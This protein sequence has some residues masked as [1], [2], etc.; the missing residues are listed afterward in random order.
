MLNISDLQVGTFLIYNGAPH[1]LIYREHSKLGRG[2]AILRSKI[3]NLLT[4]A[5]VDITFKGNDKLDEADMSR[6]KATYTYREA[7]K[8]NFM[9]STTFE[10][11]ELSKSQ[12]GTQADFLKEGVE[13]DVISWNNKP[14]NINLPFKV[15][16]EVT[17]APPAIKGNSAGAV[18]KLV[19]LETGSRINAPIFIKQGDVVKVNTQT[20]DYVERV[21]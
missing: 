8:F 5:I 17:E 6:S 4:G 9:D 20:G 2:G 7:D 13:V 10:Q 3:K 14:I 21:K 19:T 18:T 11:Y 15:D 16:L 1:Q 12:L